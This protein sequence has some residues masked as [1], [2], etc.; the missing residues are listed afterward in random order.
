MI[1]RLFVISDLHLGGGEGF[2]MCTPAGMRRLADFIQW[3]G[4]QRSA[5]RDVRLVLNGDVVDFLAERDDDGGFTAFVSDERIACAKLAAIQGRSRPVWDA[6]AGF[7][8]GG[9][10]LTLLL[11][12]HDLELCLPAVRRALLDTVGPGRVEFLYDNEGYAVGPVL[13]EHGNR[14]DDFNK[15]DHDGLRRIRSRLSRHEPLDEM[16]VQPGSDLVAR[17]MNP[18]KREYA[19]VDLLKPETTAV[20]PI[21]AVLDPGLLLG[22]PMAAWEKA[23]AAIRGKLPRVTRPGAEFVAGEE[24]QVPEDMQAAVAL[25]R[26]AQGGDE[27]VSGGEDLSI[28][29]LL[30]A[31]RQRWEKDRTSYAVDAE[32]DEYLGPAR[33]LAQGGFSTVVF[34]HTHLAKALPMGSATYLNTGTW[35]DLMRLPEKVYRGPE[36]EGRAALAQFI[37]D[38]R[39][40]RIDDFRRQ[41]P[42]FAMIDLDGGAVARQGVHF[43]DGDGK[44]APISTQGILDRLGLKG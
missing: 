3:T 4:T 28:R 26:E 15:V 8:R 16:S 38:V 7:V 33:K 23:R 18:I 19:F 14:Y 34:G 2:Q 24:E 9:S 35:A 6:L 44:H 12:N 43:Y 5:D 22:A 25:A 27:F 37:D 29:L 10:A 32:S 36:D 31:F 42:T 20:L 21:L 17:V 39:E 41:V 13:I 1:T 40:N 30:K 11:G